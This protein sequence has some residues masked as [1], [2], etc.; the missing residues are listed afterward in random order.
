LY[1]LFHA[2]D[3]FDRYIVGS[4]SIWWDEKITMQFEEE[5]A[6]A[7]TD[8]PAEVFMSVRLLEEDPE[9]PESAT[10]A[11]VTNVREMAERLNN[12][13]Y[14]GLRLTTHFWLLAVLDG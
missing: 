8:L 14:P 6:A 10:A 2:P 12:R 4:P 11:M 13:S 1:T 5:Y 3:S 7:Y 9:I